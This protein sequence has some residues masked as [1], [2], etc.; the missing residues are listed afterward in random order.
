MVLNINK[1]IVDREHMQEEKKEIIYFQCDKALKSEFYRHAQEKNI[2][3]GSVLRALMRKAI[4]SWEEEK[5]TE[6]LTKD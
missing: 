3:P 6:P 4:K 1:I 2:S 5:R